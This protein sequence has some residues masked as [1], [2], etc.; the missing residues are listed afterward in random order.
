MSSFSFRF[1]QKIITFASRVIFFAIIFPTL[2][3]SSL[4]PI[5]NLDKNFIAFLVAL[6]IV[7]QVER[8]TSLWFM[9]VSHLSLFCTVYL[10]LHIFFADKLWF[11]YATVFGFAPFIICALFLTRVFL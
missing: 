11:G 9:A 6:A 5:F 7:I 4:P 3:F 1:Y 2:C 10:V 8:A